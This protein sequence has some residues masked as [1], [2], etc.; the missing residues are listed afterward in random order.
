M[1]E[2]PLIVLKELRGNDP[3]QLTPLQQFL[4]PHVTTLIDTWILIWCA[5]AAIV[6]LKLIHEYRLHK[7]RKQ[8]R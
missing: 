3:V 1:H 6:V 8:D 5:T 2:E 4:A 7:A